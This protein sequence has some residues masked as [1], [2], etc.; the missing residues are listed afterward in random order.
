MCSK[1]NDPPGLKVNSSIL[2][3]TEKV[4]GTEVLT[5]T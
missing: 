4:K 2:Q 1:A 5:R 3:L